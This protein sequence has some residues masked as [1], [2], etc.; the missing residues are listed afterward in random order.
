MRTIPLTKEELGIPFSNLAPILQYFVTPEQLKELLTEDFEL[1][2]LGDPLES[3]PSK[4][5]SEKI[6][7][8]RRK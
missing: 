7:I 8:W 2:Y 6:M 1:E 3:E 5:G 4:I